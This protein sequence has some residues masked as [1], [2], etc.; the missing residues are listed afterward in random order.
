[1][2]DK[3]ELVDPAFVEVADSMPEHKKFTLRKWKTM[4]ACLCLVSVVAIFLHF[5]W[6]QFDPRPGEI[7]L[8]EKTTA[9]V[10][11][12]G[13]PAVSHKGSLVG[14]T[15]EEL[16]ARKNMYVFWGKVSGLTDITIDFN[17]EKEYRCIA[18]IVIDKIYQ[19]DIN[20]G[21]EITMLLP[22]AIGGVHVERV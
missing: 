10:S 4:A 15:E 13:G 9:K 11:Y 6:K 22:C 5:G 3:M 2:L 14:M 19:G 7:F 12:G 21:E 16:F 17:G 1:M 20:A 8:S 18:T